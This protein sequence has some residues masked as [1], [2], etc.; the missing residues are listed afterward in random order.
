MCYGVGAYREYKYKCK[1]ECNNINHKKE[2]IFILS[3]QLLVILL[4]VGHLWAAN[5]HGKAI[6]INDS[7]GGIIVWQSQ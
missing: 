7:V 1:C 6:M 2:K 4:P 3:P 5:E